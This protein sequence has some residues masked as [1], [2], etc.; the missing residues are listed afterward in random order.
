MYGPTCFSPII[1][2]VA[3][4]AAQCQNGEHY[5]ILLIITDGIITDMPNTKEV[6]N[7]NVAVYMAKIVT[8]KT[9]VIYIQYWLW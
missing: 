7:I 1:N 4:M 5:Y 9:S 6:S 8:N 3:Q 2:H